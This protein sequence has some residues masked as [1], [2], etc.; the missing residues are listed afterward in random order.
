MKTEHW[1]NRAAA[2]NYVKG[3]PY[4]HDQ[5]IG[6][7]REFLKIQGQVPRALDVGCG[8]GLSSIALKEIAQR[9]A[10]CDV[11]DD[12]V[13]VATPDSRID[14]LIAHAEDVP[15]P[16]ACFD[17]VTVSSAFHWFDFDRFKSELIRV[18]R[19]G[20]WAVVYDNY[21]TAQVREIPEFRQWHLEVYAKR[22]P[23]PPRHAHPKPEEFQSE[24]LS[25]LG[26]ETYENTVLFNR[27]QLIDNYL[28]HS[29]ITAAVES[30]KD[31]VAGVVDWLRNEWRQFTIFEPSSSTGGTAEFLFAGPIF[32]FQRRA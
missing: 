21:F 18:L 11:A 13:S 30:G 23:L 22:Y 6:R 1:S 2:E 28:T 8:T 10:A 29:N 14:Y 27:D 9:I 20:G 32:Y 19:P 15:F 16:A 31:T 7:V 26:K 24:E 17:L 25:V 5:V 3:R 12:M 4:H